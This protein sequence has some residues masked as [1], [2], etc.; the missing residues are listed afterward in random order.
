MPPRLIVERDARAVAV[1][2]ADRLLQALERAAVLGLATGRT[3]DPVYAELRDRLMALPP[4]H[5]Q[6]LLD[7][8][9]SFNL[10]EYVGLGPEHPGS[11]ARC[12]AEAL[13]QPLQLAPG[14]LCLPNGLAADPNLEAQRYGRSVIAVGGIDLQLL[15]LGSNG[16]VG[17]NEPPCG[18]A[19]PCRCLL[20]SA[21]TRRQ[22]CGA[23]GGDPEAVPRQAITLGT[24][25]ILSA[26][27]LLLVVTGSAKAQIL[28]R[29][30]E[31]P[32][33]ETVPASW[34]QHHPCLEVIADAEAAA[35]LRF[36]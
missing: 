12:M 33:S 6:R 1:A 9:R 16:H 5:R 15:G 17:F 31:E 8:W 30:L 3:M 21:A 34:L 11:F 2:V 10:D 14:R 13:V 26:R 19:A 29:S 35:L 28:R 18:P 20:L 23:F 7:G 32:P 36:S 24:A 4:L 25:E 22:N 27:A